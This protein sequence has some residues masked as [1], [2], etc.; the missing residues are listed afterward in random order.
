MLNCFA[1]SIYYCFGSNNRLS[2]KHNEKLTG[3]Y[4]K[5]KVVIN[6]TVKRF[7]VNV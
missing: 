4:L 7:H 1:N 3:S 2:K 6:I 5:K